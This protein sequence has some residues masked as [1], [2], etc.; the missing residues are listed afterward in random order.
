MRVF[1]FIRAVGVATWIFAKRQ[2]GLTLLAALY[3]IGF[4]WFV[5]D[6]L[7]ETPQQTQA[8]E[9]AE[10]AQTNARLIAEAQRET[11]QK[12]HKDVNKFICEL[13]S[14]CAQYGQVRQ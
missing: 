6:R 8:R 7:T 14:I 12:T 4:G 3:V 5:V 2:P 13:K 10:E 11:E 1:T 9:A